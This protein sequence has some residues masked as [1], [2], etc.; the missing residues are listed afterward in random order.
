[1]PLLPLISAVDGY[2]MLSMSTL[3]TQ[4]MATNLRESAVVHSGKKAHALELVL[5]V[6]QRVRKV[7]AFCLRVEGDGATHLPTQ[8]RDGGRS[9]CVDLNQYT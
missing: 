7:L 8:S 3:S 6:I 4:P 2:T 5:E 1:M 9:T